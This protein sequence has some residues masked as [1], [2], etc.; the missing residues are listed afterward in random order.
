MILNLN[1]SLLLGR[2][3]LYHQAER[4]EAY[5]ESTN[6]KNDNNQCLR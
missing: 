6:T 3:A 4:V 5:G 2:L 1:Y